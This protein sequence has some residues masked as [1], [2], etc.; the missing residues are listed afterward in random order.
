MSETRQPTMEEL[1]AIRDEIEKGP[2]VTI[3]DWRV[4]RLAEVGLA[5]LALR[6]REEA[7]QDKDGSWP[8]DDEWTRLAEELSDATREASKCA[9]CDDGYNVNGHKCET[10]DGSATWMVPD[11]GHPILPPLPRRPSGE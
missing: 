7:T 11:D 5:Y 9:D 2:N 4:A 1:R 10:C 6:Q 8:D 3:S